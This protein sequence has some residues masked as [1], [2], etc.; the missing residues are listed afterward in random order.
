MYFTEKHSFYILIMGT[1]QHCISMPAVSGS[2]VVEFSANF[3]ACLLS[4]SSGWHNQDFVNVGNMSHKKPWR[5]HSKQSSLWTCFRFGREI[6]SAAGEDKWEVWGEDHDTG[7]CVKT[8]WSAS[9]VSTQLLPIYPAVYA[10]TP[11]RWVIICSKC[12]V[13]V[14]C[15][16]ECTLY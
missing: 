14:Y 12:V 2:G 15:Q 3:P 11:E 16:T 1:W 5:S 7:C 9:V 6:V 4:I 8:Y 10:A 13:R